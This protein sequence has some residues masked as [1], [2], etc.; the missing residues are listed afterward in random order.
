MGEIIKKYLPEF[1]Y[2]GIDGAI[3]TFAVV[4][5]AY[6]AGFSSNV[7]I[8]LGFSNLVA[9][10]FSMSIGNYLSERSKQDEASYVQPIYSALVTFFSF[11]LLGFIPL[12]S[13]IVGLFIEVSSFNLFIYACFLTAISFIII[14]FL[15]SYIGKNSLWKGILETLLLG[16]LAAIIAYTLGDLLEKAIV[17]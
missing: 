4:A 9:D 5:G 10:G 15:K 13:Y 1:V 16:G 8:I 7:V 17:G 3:T 12:I 6:G 2:G 11:G 14:G